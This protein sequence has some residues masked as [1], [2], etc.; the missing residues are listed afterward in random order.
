M[1]TSAYFKTE[2]PYLLGPTHP[3]PTA[4]TMEP[5]PLQSS[6]FSL[7]Y[8]LLPP[9]SALEAVLLRITPKASSRTSTPAYSLTYQKR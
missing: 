6:R 1:R 7:E 3:C 9:R 2:F 4:V 5:F 8:L